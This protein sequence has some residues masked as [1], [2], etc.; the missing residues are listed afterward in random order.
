MELLWHL[1]AVGAKGSAN[2]WHTVAP[3]Q[4]ALRKYLFTQT[5]LSTTDGPIQVGGLE[6]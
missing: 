3:N 2:A 5:S 6:R 1:E 4:K